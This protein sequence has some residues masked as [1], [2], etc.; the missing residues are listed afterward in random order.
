MIELVWLDTGKVL[1]QEIDDPACSSRVGEED[2]QARFEQTG[3]VDTRNYFQVY[4]AV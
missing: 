2:I 1:Q 3:D 4:G